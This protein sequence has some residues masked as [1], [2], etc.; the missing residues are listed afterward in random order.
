MI[1]KVRE[2]QKYTTPLFVFL[3]ESELYDEMKRYRDRDIL[4]NNVYICSSEKRVIGCCGE[5]GH[6]DTDIAYCKELLI[7]VP[8]LLFFCIASY[9]YCCH[10]QDYF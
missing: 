1:F 6:K 3:P 9:M 4:L 2:F 8:C 5:E 7:E 10:I